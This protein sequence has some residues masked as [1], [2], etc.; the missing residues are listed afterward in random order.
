MLLDCTLAD[1]NEKIYLLFFIVY[2]AWA[3]PVFARLFCD[4]L[5][6]IWNPTCI[7]IP[8][9]LRRCTFPTTALTAACT[10]LITART[11]ILRSGNINVY[12]ANSAVFVLDVINSLNAFEHVL[13]RIVHRI[14]ACSRIKKADD[15]DPN[16]FDNG[17]DDDTF[18]K[19]IACIRIAVH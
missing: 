18:A 1:R 3:D 5:G 7:S 9:C 2:F 17:I 11:S 10:V 13:N 6:R 19:I 16:V 12:A 14:L 15:I 4:V 8:L